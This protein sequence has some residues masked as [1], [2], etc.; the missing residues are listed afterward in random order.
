MPDIGPVWADLR[1][2]H[3]VTRVLTPAG[4]PAWLVTGYAEAK[5]L[6]SDPQL[7]RSHRTSETASRMSNAGFMGG[8][9]GDF[10]AEPAFHARLR[11]VLAP[12]FSA[13]RMGR[14]E[15]GYS[16]WPTPSWTT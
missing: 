2:R 11:R 8:P 4:D 16:G 14:L 6:F 1:S 9:T 15:G 5:T 13:R 12:S 3:P 7:G 10:D